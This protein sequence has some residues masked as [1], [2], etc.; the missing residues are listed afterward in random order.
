MIK[1]VINIIF[2]F[3]ILSP[4]GLY[5][6]VNKEQ[7]GKVI[8]SSYTFNKH[9]SKKEKKIARKVNKIIINETNKDFPFVLMH[10]TYEGILNLKNNTYHDNMEVAYQTYSG[11][12]LGGRHNTVNYDGEHLFLSL[13]LD[14]DQEKYAIKL[15]RY[16]MENLHEL[17][18][19]EK[20]LRVKKDKA[21]LTDGDMNSFKLRKSDLEQ[22]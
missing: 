21:T 2:V 8:F 9:Y 3:V 10:I 18:E 4:S 1:S 11:E 14:A 12:F 13:A 20:L 16:A 15:L 19:K 5:G 22:Y 7:I 6:Q 17:K